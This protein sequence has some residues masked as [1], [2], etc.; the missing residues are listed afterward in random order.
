MAVG[1]DHAADEPAEI[2]PELARRR[3]VDDAQP[4]PAAALDAHDLRVGK[5][6]VIGQE[7]VEVNVIQVHSLALHP[8]FAHPRHG[9]PRHR[10]AGHVWFRRTGAGQAGKHLVRRAKGEVVQHEDDLLPVVAKLGGVMHDE[11][12]RHQP[13]LLHAVMRMHPVRA[14][15]RRIVVALHRAVRDRRGLR[16]RESILRPRRQLPMPVDERARAGFVGQCDAEPFVGGEADAGPSVRTDQSED[17]GRPSVDLD[18]ARSGDEA[19]RI[20]R[21]GADGAGDHGQDAGRQ[22]GAKQLAARQGLLTMEVLIDYHGYVCS[23]PGC[24]I[25]CRFGRASADGRAAHPRGR[26]DQ[27]RGAANDAGD[28]HPER[29]RRRFGVRLS[30]ARTG[31]RRSKLEA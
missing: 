29:R 24:W 31:A 6:S 7:G 2:D 21:C 8:R 11:R 5:R 18:H 17:L 25:A 20:E 19:L 1:R 10:H 14:G 12:R 4:D 23:V 30:A 13:L 16:P 28:G 27:C 3:A 22:R 15:D 9:H 26:A